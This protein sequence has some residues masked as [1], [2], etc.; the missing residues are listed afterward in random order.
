MSAN[1]AFLRCFKYI[2]H[3]IV[4]ISFGIPVKF[5]RMIQL[6][7]HPHTASALKP[8]HG[9]IEHAVM[10]TLK[11]TSYAV[12]GFAL[13]PVVMPGF[14]FGGNASDIAANLCSA[15]AVSAQTGWAGDIAGM[16]APLP[17]IGASLATAGL[18]SVAIA[19][20]V[21]IGGIFLARHL[22]KRGT[23][24]YGVSAGKIIRWA[25]LGTSILFALPAILGGITM[26]LHFLATMFR[27]PGYATASM[28][29]SPDAWQVSLIDSI[30]YQNGSNAGI[31]DGL[32][33][34]ANTVGTVATASLAGGALGSIV[35]ALVCCVP[36]GLVA[37]MAGEGKEK[38]EAAPPAVKPV[39]K[40]R[41]PIDGATKL[42][43]P[44]QALPALPA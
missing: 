38:P 17:I 33:G 39:Y 5:P 43:A 18:P 37:W 16:L 24:F 42:P 2:L 30:F 19:A 7:K 32:T 21:G 31:A 3:E 26:S 15:T 28:T 27:Y 13:L 22:E 34:A 12:A 40:V 9:P 8:H 11:Y 44:M 6:A 36:A 1:Q 14:G 4:T 41:T 35:A 25:A 20:A 29:M 10:E 23:Q